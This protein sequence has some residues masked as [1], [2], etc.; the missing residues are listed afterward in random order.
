MPF[1]PILPERWPVLAYTSSQ[2]ALH[3]AEDDWI[4]DSGCSHHMTGNK[5][6]IRNLAPLTIPFSVILGDKSSISAISQGPATL[7]ALNLHVLFVPELKVNLISC[8]Q[9]TSGE[10][11]SILL[12]AEGGLYLTRMEIDYAMSI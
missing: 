9:L 10:K 8:S 3:L 1:K 6:L 7:C 5:D 2:K 12:N 4:L 11:C